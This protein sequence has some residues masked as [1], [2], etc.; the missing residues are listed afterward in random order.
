MV[1]HLD[2]DHA[3]VWEK[4]CYNVIRPNN[5]NKITC[6]LST[7]TTT[8]MD[9]TLLTRKHKVTVTM[10]RFDTTSS[11]KNM[12]FISGNRNHVK[13]PWESIFSE[14]WLLE[15]YLINFNRVS[16][17]CLV[18]EC[19]ICSYKS[20]D[21]ITLTIRLSVSISVSPVTRIKQINYF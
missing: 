7:V 19:Q 16:R 6:E 18:N 4:R 10:L 17:N 1:N 20:T 5:R 21:I 9:N 13:W 2:T 3:Q 11:R 12:H 14:K 15:K 8:K